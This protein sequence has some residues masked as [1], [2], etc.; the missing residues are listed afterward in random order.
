MQWMY[1]TG[2]LT[3]IALLIESLLWSDVESR[4]SLSI[5]SRALLQWMSIYALVSVQP[6]FIFALKSMQ[7][8]FIFEL[9]N[10]YA[11][12]VHTSNA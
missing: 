8:M 6:M 5:L 11:M 7:W 12:D 2:S 3:L 1:Y 4:P 10:E 9:I